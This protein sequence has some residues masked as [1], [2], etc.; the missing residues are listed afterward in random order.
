MLDAVFEEVS[1]FFN[2]FFDDNSKFSFFFFLSILGGRIPVSLPFFTFLP[3]IRS[4]LQRENEEFD[5]L[6]L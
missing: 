4:I 5:N 6:K 1:S 2:E 3:I